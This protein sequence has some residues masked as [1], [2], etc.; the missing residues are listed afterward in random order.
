MEPP[1]L[2]Q[3]SL[4]FIAAV[5]LCFIFV[6]LERITEERAGVLSPGKPI[7][8]EFKEDFDSVLAIPIVPPIGQH[9]ILIVFSS[10]GSR[11]GFTSKICGGFVN[12]LAKTLAFGHRFLYVTVLDSRFDPLV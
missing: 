4:E 8:W 5:L 11:G 10:Y 1:P 7:D 9:L 3:G 12:G 6:V 2:D